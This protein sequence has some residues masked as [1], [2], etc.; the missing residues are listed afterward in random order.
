MAVEQY[1]IEGKIIDENFNIIPGIEVSILT[2]GSN[3]LSSIKS[4]KDGEYSLN[5]IL[6]IDENKIPLEKPSLYK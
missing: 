2:F 6:L 1:K 4:D 3:K 5:I